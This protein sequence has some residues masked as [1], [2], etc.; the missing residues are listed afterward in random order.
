MVFTGIALDHER[1][2]EMYECQKCNYRIVII[3]EETEL[4]KYIKGVKAERKR[5][6]K[7]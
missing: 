7:V 2:G 3:K 5:K 6:E 1:D 4:S